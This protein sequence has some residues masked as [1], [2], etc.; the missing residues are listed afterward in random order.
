[1]SVNLQNLQLAIQKQIAV[2]YYSKSD[3]STY[4]KKLACQCV[5]GLKYL[6]TSPIRMDPKK[7]KPTRARSGR[8]KTRTARDSTSLA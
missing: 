7:L 4:K 6:I 5:F 8:I 1:M 2:M 3:P